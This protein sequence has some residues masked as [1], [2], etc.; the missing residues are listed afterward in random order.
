MGITNFLYNP[1]RK[2]KQ[3]L[4][5]EFV[6]RQNVLDII[7]EDIENS[8]MKTPEQHYLLIGQRGAGKT[9]LLNRIRYAIEDSIRLKDWLIPVI[10]SEEQY[11][12]GDLANLWENVAQLLEDYHG[13]EGI[14]P[15]M[16]KYVSFSDFEEHCWDILE[17]QLNKKKKKLVLLIDNIGDLLKKLDDLEVRR[18]RMILQTKS[19]IRVIAASPLYL[20]S[21]LD[22]KQPLFEF[23]KVI[24]LE[25]LSSRETR[26]LLIKLADIHA[27]KG[28]I[29]RIIK[30]TPERIETL[31]ALTGGVPRTMALMFNIFIEHENENSLKDLER[32]LDVVTP[33]YK[34]R[35]DD[36]PAQQQKI[37]DAV[38]KYWDPISVKELKDRV[39]LESK[40]ISAQLRQLE[41]NQV[42][43]K[44]ETGNKNH[45]YILKERFFNI[46]YLMRY[47]RKDDKQ[48]VIWLVRFLESWC[49]DDEI[50]MRIENFINQIKDQKLAQYHIDFFG[51]VYSSINRL[52]LQSKLLLKTSVHQRHR[53]PLL[54]TED[55][56]NKAIDES[57][58]Q[59]DYKMS[60]KWMAMLDRLTE[61]H[62]SLVLQIIANMLQN[63][64][65]MILLTE[66]FISL[67]N[68]LNTDDCIGTLTFCSFLHI[69][70]WMTET[71][72]YLENG[73]FEKA[74]L[75]IKFQLRESAHF[76]RLMNQLN[77]EWD[78]EF[79]TRMLLLAIK[80]FYSKGQI[81]SLKKIFSL[82]YI[83]QENDQVLLAEIFNPIYLAVISLGPDQGIINMAPEK[84]EIVRQI[85]DFIAAK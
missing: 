55:E 8:S 26:E 36:L 35:M 45:E 49:T 84:E 63:E 17:A 65:Q 80:K 44:L 19:Q 16:G 7:M 14:Y 33:L 73:E 46:W 85:K 39:R 40:V 15:E 47:G 10:F 32:I 25:G 20:E 28:I 74:I 5:A 4:I 58:L 48:K 29:N 42:V 69:A 23:F 83:D 38:A 54:F 67:L 1:E 68:E 27:E 34:H 9:T 11:N 56:L 2:G 12:I 51:E 76:F 53:K 79:E 72:I 6:I 3:Q 60:L 37:V 61:S 50:D 82:E 24:R 57:F 77:L 70:L 43:Q 64:S 59:G 18:L 22:Y 62:K 71:L 13:F 81:N 52:T 78:S 21:V 30:E 41:K 75:G 66:I 31:R